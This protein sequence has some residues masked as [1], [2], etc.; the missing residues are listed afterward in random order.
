L[1]ATNTGPGVGGRLPG[2]LAAG[3]DGPLADGLG[4]GGG[5]AEAVAGQGLAQRRLGPA[6]LFG[7]R[8]D[9]AELFGEL[10]GP[11]GLGPVGQE[12]AGLPAQRVMIVPRSLLRSGLGYEQVLSEF[13]VE[14]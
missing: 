1:R 8:V 3:S 5:H 2:A 4:F 7:G 14:L 13:D 6:Q 11:F 10:E 12:A 9:T